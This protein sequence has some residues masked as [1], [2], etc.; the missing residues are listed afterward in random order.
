MAVKFDS[1]RV[2]LHKDSQDV[3]IFS[4]TGIDFTT[5]L[6]LTRRA[7]LK[8]II[9]GNDRIWFS[10]AFTDAKALLAECEKRRARA[11]RTDAPSIRQIRLSER[12]DEGLARGQ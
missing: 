6:P 12:K 11:S 1:Y 5:R 8:K 7:K 10:E 9:T 4:R 3:V 2:Q